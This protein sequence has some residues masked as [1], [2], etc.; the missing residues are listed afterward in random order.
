MRPR[1]EF[2]TKEE[3]QLNMLKRKIDRAII[4]KKGAAK[5]MK[6]F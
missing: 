5:L 6:T 2:N 1:H 4:S 3:E